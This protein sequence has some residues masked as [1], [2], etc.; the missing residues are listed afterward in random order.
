M[1]RSPEWWRGIVKGKQENITLFDVEKLAGYLGVQVGL[2][3]RI[4]PV[5]NVENAL[6][7]DRQLYDHS[8]EIVLAAYRTARTDGQRQAVPRSKPKAAASK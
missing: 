2:R 4:D 7:S 8:R 1:G 6:A 5:V 3:G